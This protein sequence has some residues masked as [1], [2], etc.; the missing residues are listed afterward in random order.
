LRRYLPLAP[1]VPILVFLISFFLNE[2]TEYTMIRIFIISALAIFTGKVYSYNIVVAT[3]GSGD[4]TTVQQAFAQVPDNNQNTFTIFVKK[5]TYKE[6]LRLTQLK[7]NVTLIGEEKEFTILTYDDYG[8]KTGVGGTD[9]SYST[10]IE[11][12][13]FSAENITFENTIDSRLAAYATG[14]QA[15]ALM[16]KGDRTTISNCIIR[17]FQDTFY[18]KGL[19]RTYVTCSQIEG[20]TDFIFGAG[21]AVFE[22][23]MII[24]KKNSHTTAAANLSKGN[25]YNY[26]FLNCKLVA[27]EGTT[28]TTLGRPWKAYARV[29]YMNCDEGSHIKPEGWSD[30]SSASYD[31]SAYFAEYQ[32]TGDGFKPASRLVWTHQ[33]SDAEANEYTLAKIFAAN[34]ASPAYTA[35]WLPPLDNS[36]SI[37][38]S[39]NAGMQKDTQ[40]MVTPNPGSSLIRFSLSS[41]AP[42]KL[43]AT[44]RIFDSKGSFIREETNVPASNNGWTLN[45]ATLSEGIYLY[46]LITSGEMSQGKF[47][48]KS[49]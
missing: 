6:K 15:V 28:S 40:M 14:G 48:K 41:G 20:T 45:I 10:L 43:Q 17:G 25:K 5:G 11:A 26:V 27:A 39:V 2:L 3:D 38:M 35:D 19:G 12:N 33:L 9:N 31:T 47:V 16:V 37:P 42:A 44:I 46:Q 22:N 7:H 29:V 4:V 8:S 49:E 21:I 30:W 36:C 18:T 23:C 24:N 34:A 1:V 13:G 32:C